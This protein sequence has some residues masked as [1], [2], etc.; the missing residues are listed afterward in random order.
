M[1][2][3]RM[4]GLNWLVAEIDLPNLGG[5]FVPLSCRLLPISDRQQLAESVDYER[6]LCSTTTFVMPVAAL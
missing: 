6:L 1:I 3:L 2:I 4:A 5:S